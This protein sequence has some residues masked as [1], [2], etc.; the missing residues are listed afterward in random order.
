MIAG[1][2]TFSK[3][4]CKFQTPY[5]GI[6]D[7]HTHA[8]VHLYLIEGETTFSKHSRNGPVSV[9]FLKEMPVK[10]F[11]DKVVVTATDN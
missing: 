4:R 5:T 9:L 10:I 2:G 6:S 7:I 3:T 8:H 1:S 11:E